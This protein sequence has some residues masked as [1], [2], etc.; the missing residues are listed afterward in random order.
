MFLGQDIS[1]IGVQITVHH[2]SSSSTDKEYYH[3]CKGSSV[4]LI[5][6]HGSGRAG[7]PYEESLTSG[8]EL[9]KETEWPGLLVKPGEN[10]TGSLCYTYECFPSK[11]DYEIHKSAGLELRDA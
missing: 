9:S 2:A 1:L 3:L 4:L 10:A 5:I 11:C 8:S 7:G 6:S